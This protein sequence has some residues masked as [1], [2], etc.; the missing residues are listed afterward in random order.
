M[1]KSPTYLSESFDAIHGRLGELS[2]GGEDGAVLALDFLLAAGAASLCS[3]IHLEPQADRLRIRFRVLGS[4]RTA[5][6]LPKDQGERLLARLKVAAKLL[7]YQRR[8]PQDGR[9]RI[10]FDGVDLDL[11]VSVFPVVHGE[12]A[13]VRFP[14]SSKPLPELAELGLPEGSRRALEEA[15]AKTQ[16]TILLTGPAGS[17]KTTTMYAALRHVQ[18]SRADTCNIVTLEDPVERDLEG[19]TQSQVHPAGGLTFASGLRAILRQDPDVILIGEVRD[20]ETAEIAVQ[21]GLTG[22]LILSTIHSGTAAG[23]FTRLLHLDVE[24]FLVGS[25]VTCVLAQRLVRTICPECAEPARVPEAAAKLVAE[26]KLS[27]AAFLRGRGCAKCA[28]S[29]FG[30]RTGVFELLTVDDGLRELLMRRAPTKDLLDAARKAGHRSLL[31]AA[32]V[33]AAAGRTTLEEALKLA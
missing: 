17:G 26:A 33:A 29:G 30:G 15:L 14:G 23:V 19:M 2:R 20:R 28:K 25:S 11:R 12:K 22:H 24:A 13:V 8:V 1:A 16:G 7:T 10:V 31:D 3:D 32:L 18:S 4:L 27:G 21:A 5:A 9:A 6:W